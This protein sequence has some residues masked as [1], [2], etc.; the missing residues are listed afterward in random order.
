MQTAFEQLIKIGQKARD[1]TGSAQN[2]MMLSYPYVFT[3]FIGPI[4]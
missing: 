4:G 2:H 1:C 3:I